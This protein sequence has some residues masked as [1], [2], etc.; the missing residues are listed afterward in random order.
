MSDLNALLAQL[1]NVS[2]QNQ[3]PE[4][5]VNPPPDDSQLSSL[6]NSLS[7]SSQPPQTQAS[8][9][10]RSSLE[11]LQNLVQSNQFNQQQA[12]PTSSSPSPSQQL[13]Q[14]QQQANSDLQAVL[15]SL[16]NVSSQQSAPQQN[17]SP[18]SGLL[19][20]S[21][22]QQAQQQSALS[23]LLGQSSQPSQTQQ[24]SLSSL[25][26]QS[27]QP[28]QTQQ[29]SL[30]SLL[31]QSS[32][33]TQQP[34]SSLSSL[35][36]TPPSAQAPQQSQSNSLSS[37][38]SGLSQP[39]AQSTSP[40]SSLLG[41]SSTGTGGLAAPDS[42]LSSL[43][44][45]P[46][47][48]PTAGSEI[49]TNL[50]L[51]LKPLDLKEKE[52]F[53]YK[54][55]SSNNQF[56]NHVTYDK[57]TSLSNFISNSQPFTVIEIPGGE[58]ELNIS[59]KSPIHIK[60]ANGQKVTLKGTGNSEVIQSASPYLILEGLDIDQQSTTWGALVI[61]TGF[62][63]ILKCDIK[64]ANY[65]PLSIQGST[66]TND[67]NAYVEAEDCHFT[68]AE[69]SCIQMQRDSSLYVKNSVIEGSQ[70]YGIWAQSGSQCYVDKGCVIRSNTIAGINVQKRCKLRIES[71][72]ELVD[73]KD[74][75]VEI[76]DESVAVIEGVKVTGTGHLAAIYS[77]F[78]SFVTIRNSQIEN[79]Q[80]IALRSESE[81]TI[82][83]TDNKFSDCYSSCFFMCHVSSFIQSE[84]D[85]I[86][87]SCSAAVVSIEKGYIEC[88]NLSIKD[89]AGVGV[90]SYDHASI[91]MTNS[92]ISNITQVAIQIR[93]WSKLYLEDVGISNSQQTGISLTHNA[94]AYI[95][96][97]Q[98]SRTNELGIQIANVNQG[99]VDIV[100]CESFEN[101]KG[102]ILIQDNVYE[103]RCNIK[104]CQFN[105]NGRL[106]VNANGNN[107]MP[108]FE[109]CSFIGNAVV[110][111]HVLNGAEITLINSIFKGEGQ[112][113]IVLNNAIAHVEK[114]EFSDFQTSAV[115]C[116]NAGNATITNCSIHDN[117]SFG[118]HV[119]DDNTHV[120]FVNCIFMNHNRSS[121]LHAS[122]RAV[123][124][125][126]D[127][128]IQADLEPHAHIYNGAKVSMK[129][130]DLTNSL[131]GVGVYV[132]DDGIFKC[133][134]VCIHDEVSKAIDIGKKG[135]V[136]A[137]DSKFLNNANIGIMVEQYGSGTFTNCLF[138]SN[139]QTAISMNGGNV[140][141]NNCTISNHEH[142]GI[143]L[144][145]S[146][147]L[148]DNNTKFSKN[149][150]NNIL[151]VE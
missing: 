80:S 124:R 150:Q 45:K 29:S 35:L 90:V 148:V 142:Q 85:T 123:I 132:R 23:G 30:S 69:K 25:L 144:T 95:K 6:L 110:G 13:S 141:L 43:V 126:V 114:A 16:M 64:S 74:S 24:S 40:L 63:K 1:S 22:Q 86:S 93:D 15:A 96:H 37:L 55:R 56:T 3:Q 53:P 134:N 38:L 48:A 26:G 50:A 36:S 145:K 27:S 122:N 138:D 103:G 147:N 79:N 18:L 140:T 41:S 97:C 135:V 59:I 8:T 62:T 127:T 143:C 14:S 19:G 101:N 136:I 47:S 128:K 118:C 73:N 39:P 51:E 106:G 112:N 133:N 76:V 12:Q 113:G 115:T 121:T 92:K 131:K 111:A 17:Q 75:G 87:G 100:D 70:M 84:N 72:V 34:T 20:Q 83:S 49:K 33:P 67:D 116:S 94:I 54:K 28:S 71:G 78:N 46:S 61:S 9:N 5:P 91:R 82:L 57:S 68:G 42:S 89:L 88:R 77:C 120:K 108:R 146:S 129:N 2:S 137:V 139:G 81:S 21:H 58:Y 65:P 105:K 52:V 32:Q 44:S 107:T 7:N 151:Y 66:A 125:C 102:G 98:I 119:T 149:G 31:G 104:D 109:N 10:T 4:T 117:C 11:G 60:S 130:C 99:F